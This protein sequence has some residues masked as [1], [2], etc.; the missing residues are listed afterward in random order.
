MPGYERLAPKIVKDVSRKCI[1]SF[2]KE[3]MSRRCQESVKKILG[4]CQKVSGKD[5]GSVVEISRKSAGSFKE[6]LRRR[7]G[8]VQR[9]FLEREIIFQ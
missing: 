2:E 9:V 7:Q 3:I 8:S 4:K 1:E 5:Q 6:V